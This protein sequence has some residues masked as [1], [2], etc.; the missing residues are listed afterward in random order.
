MS[1]PVYSTQFYAAKGLVGDGSLIT[2]PPGHT[3]VV[4]QLT[5]YSNP[6]F[7][8]C[9]GFFKDDDSGADLFSCAATSGAPGWF[10]FFGTLVFG[11]GQSFFWHV[12]RFGSDDADVSAH[13][14][15]LTDS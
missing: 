7:G 9:R 15:D 4:K 8:V 2:V 11:P 12:D 13:G 6:T 5:F 14:F 3:Y 1:R 10:G